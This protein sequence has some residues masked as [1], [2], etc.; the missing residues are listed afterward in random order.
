M[1]DTPPTNALEADSLVGLLNLLV[2][3]PEPA[4]V[5]MMPQTAGWAVLAGCFGLVLMWQAWRVWRRYQ[6]NA[7]RRE[8]LRALDA[9]GT[10]AVEISTILKRV[11]L[12]VY[13]RKRV[14]GLSGQAWL[15]FLDETGGGEVFRQGAGRVLSNVAFVPNPQSGDAALISVAREWIQHH[16]QTA[17][18]GGDD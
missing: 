10:D 7:Y 15:R 4:P 17:A 11:A 13:G 1:S 14:A 12:T 9:A 3:V 8:A 5:S 2:E 18:G 16:D 6:A